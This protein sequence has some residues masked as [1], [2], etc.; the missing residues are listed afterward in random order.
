MNRRCSDCQ[1][2]LSSA[3]LQAVPN[4]AQCVECLAGRGDVDRYKDK[5]R[6][7]FNRAPELQHGG[8]YELEWVGHEF[9]VAPIAAFTLG[10]AA[11]LFQRGA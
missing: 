10:E 5:L 6:S 11:M 9:N 7:A 3:R 2:E 4:A 1:A 8:E